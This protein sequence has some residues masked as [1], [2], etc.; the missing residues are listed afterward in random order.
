MGVERQDSKEDTHDIMSRVEDRIH[1]MYVVK[2]IRG[3]YLGTHVM[4]CC[5]VV[6]AGLSFFI[7]EAFDFASPCVGW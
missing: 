4:S 7:C 5:N 6:D 1:V 2:K 3:S